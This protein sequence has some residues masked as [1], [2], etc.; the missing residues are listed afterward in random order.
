MAAAVSQSRLGERGSPDTVCA[1]DS[2]GASP[3]QSA[4]SPASA[5]AA[6]AIR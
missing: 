3:I 1:T 6:A 4:T 2:S 5:F